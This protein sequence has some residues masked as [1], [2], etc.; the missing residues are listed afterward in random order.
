MRLARRYYFSAENLATDVFLKSQMD[1]MSSVSVHTIAKFNRIRQHAAYAP[2]DAIVEMI[3]EACTDSPPLRVLEVVLG[4]PPVIADRRISSELVSPS[5]AFAA[6]ETTLPG[7]PAAISGANR[8]TANLFPVSN[9]HSA[10]FLCVLAHAWLRVAVG[11]EILC[12][13]T[14]RIIFQL[15]GRRLR[16]IRSMTS[17]FRLPE[18]AARALMDVFHTGHMGAFVVSPMHARVLCCLSPCAT[19]PA[20]LLGQ[21]LTGR[22][23]G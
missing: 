21:A 14:R 11:A 1:Q 3:V 5:G 17:T 15:F 7:P 4:D 12:A 13:T 8:W 16:G 20:C 19:R 2:H 18:E 23:S 9:F 6:A 22:F 10:L